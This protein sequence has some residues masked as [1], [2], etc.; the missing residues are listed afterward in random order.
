MNRTLDVVIDQASWGSKP[1][2]PELIARTGKRDVNVLAALLFTAIATRPP[3]VRG[4][5]LSDSW[6][7]F[8][9]LPAMANGSELRLRPEW[10]DVDT[11]QKRVLS[12]ELGVG[13]TIQ[14]VTEALDCVDFADTLYLIKLIDPNGLYLISKAKR[15]PAKSPDYILIDRS[16]KYIVLECKGTQSSRRELRDAISRGRAQKQNVGSLG[17]S[18]IKHS[19]V[20]GLFIPQ[21]PVAEDPCILVADPEGDELH[22]ILSNRPKQQIDDALTQLTLAKQL[23]LAGLAAL[24]T[25]LSSAEF[26]HLESLPEVARAELHERRADSKEDYRV[27]FDSANLPARAEPVENQFRTRFSVRTPTEIFDRLMSDRERPKMV[28]D[29]SERRSKSVWHFDASNFRAELTTPL[30]FSFRLEAEPK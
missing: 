30:G 24:P 2:P 18:S 6:A 28:S 21:W 20:A 25:W 10:E 29:L 14:F 26:A 9:Y 8:R 22:R 7:W 5:D 19:L 1:V 27:V 11:H 16:S 3:T 23:A 4:F 12:D 15:G 17:S 13:F